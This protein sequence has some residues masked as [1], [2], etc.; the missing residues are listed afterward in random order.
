MTGHFSGGICVG[1]VSFFMSGLEQ[2]AVKA[3]YVL[4][5]RKGPFACK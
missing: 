2:N 3:Y 1:R 4:R 5:E